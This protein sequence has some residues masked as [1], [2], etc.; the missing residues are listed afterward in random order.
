MT[1]AS[2]TRRVAG[3]VEEVASVGPWSSYKSW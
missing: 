2:A 3:V 1:D